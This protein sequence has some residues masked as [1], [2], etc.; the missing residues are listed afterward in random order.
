M[1]ERHDPPDPADS[2]MSTGV[3]GAPSWI[4]QAQGL[5][6]PLAFI[7]GL[8]VAGAIGVLTPIPAVIA[9]VLAVQAVRRRVPH[10]GI[11]LGV[12][13]I[14]TMIGTWLMF[15]NPFLT[16]RGDGL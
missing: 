15:S 14:A 2:V 11:A 7:Y 9:V 16:S 8:S 13:L 5:R 10:A 4:E 6:F 12:A 3:T 1:S